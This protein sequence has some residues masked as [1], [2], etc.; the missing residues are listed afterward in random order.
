LPSGIFLAYSEEEERHVS[1][2]R[3][4]VQ[5][6]DLTLAAFEDF[7][8]FYDIDIIQAHLYKQEFET[9]KRT[10]G[11]N[12]YYDILIARLGLFWNQVPN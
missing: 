11:I 6:R 9:A 12:R 10:F 8:S 3:K 7:A 1:E 5:L 2:R 4:A